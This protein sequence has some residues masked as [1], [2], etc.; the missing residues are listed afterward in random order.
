MRPARGAAPSGPVNLCKIFYVLAV[1]I[2]GTMKVSV[3]ATMMRA[4]CRDCAYSIAG[5]PSEVRG[6]E[7]RALWQAQCSASSAKDL[8]SPVPA[9]LSKEKNAKE[10]LKFLV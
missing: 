9:R 8:R 6:G 4:M 7:V 10:A 2:A 5:S 3:T 1:L